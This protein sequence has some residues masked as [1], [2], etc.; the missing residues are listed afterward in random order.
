V[1]NFLAKGEIVGGLG[2]NWY[3]YSNLSVDRG[4]DVHIVCSRLTGQLE[5]E[6]IEGIKVH[7]VSSSLGHRSSL[8]GE[9]AKRCLK[10]ILEIEPDLV[11]G[12]NAYHISTVLQR[13]K[14]RVPILTHLHGSMDLDLFG[15]KL[16][17]QSDFGR[18]LRDRLYC[19]FSMWKKNY[20]TRHAD[21]IIANSKYTADS[22]YRYFPHKVVKVV[23]NGVD[24]EHFRP[25]KSHLKD[26]YEGQRLLLFVGRPVPFKGIQ[27]LIHAMSKLNKM[28]SD[29]TCL[30]VGVKRD[31]G[32]YQ[33]Y[34]RWLR[35]IVEGLRL[36]NVLFLGPVPHF[37]LPEYYSAADCL[38]I[39]SYP[40]P[41]PSKVL[42]EGQ[43]C[44]CPIVATNG[45]G[46]P[47]IFGRKSGLLFRPRNVG[48]LVEKI[49]T[50]LRDPDRFK[51][52]RDLVKGTATW[53]TCVKN[54]IE[55]YESLLDT[56]K[57]GIS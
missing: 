10:T 52:G 44:S 38:I 21:L 32:Y 14:I 29:L 36:E 46:I 56:D 57:I 39:P 37:N 2:P 5:E 7:R 12:H 35:S 11:H 16:P 33:P 22:V 47:E 4:I 8:Y 25:V 45:G 51:E 30:L 49:K 20:V 55:C 31:E 48:D 26:F 3:Y 27:Y 50:V 42:L 53:E 43:A 54:M 19:I 17:F 18:A 41:A 6:D 1:D 24:L 40:E 28:Y 15:D 23:Y 34:Y 13:H 9:F